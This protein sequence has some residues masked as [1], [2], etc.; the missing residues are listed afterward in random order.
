M[1]VSR[2]GDVVAVLLVVAGVGWFTVGGALIVAGVL[3][4]VLADS[5]SE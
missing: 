4:A 2:V 3:V 1:M 5:W